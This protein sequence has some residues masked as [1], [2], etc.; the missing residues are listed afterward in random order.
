MHTRVNLCGALLA[1]VGASLLPLT[2]PPQPLSR[3]TG[4]PSVEEVMNRYVHAIGGF[5][6][7]FRH[8]S[9]TLRGKFILSTLGPALERTVYYKDGKILYV[10]KLPNGQYKEGYDGT[11]AWKLHPKTGAALVQGDEV[12][13]KQ[14]DADMY[15]PARI[16][17]YFASMEV[18]DVAQFEGHT[19]YHLRGTNKWKQINEHF[20]DTTN[21][22]LIGYRFDSAWRGGPG[23]ESEVFSDYKDVGGWLIPT[24]ATHKSTD[25]EQVE[26]TTTVSFDDVADSIFELP[27]EVKAL[28]AARRTALPT[29]G[30]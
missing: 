3:S 30:G 13:S 27:V 26:V 20:Y 6:A 18:V 16:L 1:A 24:R 28:L 17:D 21:G 25:G 15:Y 14:R 12:K 11:V 29:R 8:K 9:M 4:L 19:C 2:L 23:Q 22:L 7:I 10:I 5:E